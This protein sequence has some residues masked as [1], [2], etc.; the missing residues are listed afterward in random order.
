MGEE[1]SSPLR[2]MASWIFRVSQGSSRSVSSSERWGEEEAPGLGSSLP[3]R[4][5]VRMGILSLLSETR[6]S[7]SWV[8]RWVMGLEEGSPGPSS[9]VSRSVVASSETSGSLS[10]GASASAS[11]AAAEM[12]PRGRP[13]RPQCSSLSSFSNEQ[14]GQVIIVSQAVGGEGRRFGRWPRG[15]S[16]WRRSWASLTTTVGRGQHVVGEE[17]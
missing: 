11:G 7:S 3:E 5:A 6:D 14:V 12:S 16:P 4:A 13:Q 8:A 9:R 10:L 15:S 2:W 17:R 1:V